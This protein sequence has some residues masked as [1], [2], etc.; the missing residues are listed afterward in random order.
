MTLDEAKEI[1]DAILERNQKKE[2][3]LP[4]WLQNLLGTVTGWLKRLLADV[5]EFLWKLLV[6]ILEWLGKLFGNM[7]IVSGGGPSPV[8]SIV[9]LVLFLLLLAAMVAAVWLLVSRVRR[10]GKEKPKIADED[11]LELEELV[12]RPEDVLLLAE[13]Y[14]G[15]GDIAAAFRYLVLSLLVQMNRREVIAVRIYKTNRMYRAEMVA[16]GTVLEEEI[17]PMFR[18]FN[19][20]RFGRRPITRGEYDAFRAQYDRLLQDVDAR[21]AA[22]G[23]RGKAG[24]S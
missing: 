6:K 3:S 12:S 22:G 14:L 20:V 2:L 4:G 8:I 23:K 17:T 16:S 18:K 15:L 9:A 11:A 19:A 7:K 10:R 21:L 13:K 5:A 24:R 1:L